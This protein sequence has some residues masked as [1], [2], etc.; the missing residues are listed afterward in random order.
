MASSSSLAP[1]QSAATFRDPNNTSDR[2]DFAIS[3]GSK[4]NQHHAHIIAADDDDDGAAGNVPPYGNL[5]G[6]PQTVTTYVRYT[7]PSTSNLLGIT[8]DLTDS[9]SASSPRRETPASPKSAATRFMQKRLARKSWTWTHHKVVFFREHGITPTMTVSEIVKPSKH[10]PT[11][12]YKEVRS[13]PLSEILDVEEAKLPKEDALPFAAANGMSCEYLWGELV[14]SLRLDDTTVVDVCF[15]SAMER[16]RWCMW[17]RELISHEH[18]QDLFASDVTHKV[19]AHVLDGATGDAMLLT[20][21]GEFIDFFL[22]PPQ[23]LL[24]AGLS[25]MQDTVGIVASTMSLR[26]VGSGVM[27]NNNNNNKN[28]IPSAVV[29]STSEPLNGTEEQ[30]PASSSSSSS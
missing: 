25:A 21:I 12:T 26:R 18:R 27:H 23:S 15:P 13:V 22:S 14:I 19:S 17:L 9:G 7:L 30:R 28:N 3:N 1:M 29:G 20:G 2:F 10:N 16:H 24:S 4:K 11:T 8:L 6:A 5:S